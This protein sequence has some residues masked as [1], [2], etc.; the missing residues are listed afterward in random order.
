MLHLGFSALSAPLRLH[1]GFR[2]T[3]LRLHLGPL[4]VAEAARSPDAAAPG[5]FNL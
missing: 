5:E 1:L 2:R 4:G 3:S